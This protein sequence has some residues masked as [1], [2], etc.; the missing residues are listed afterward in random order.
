MP[1]MCFGRGRS[2]RIGTMVASRPAV[3]RSTLR[4]LGLA[5]AWFDVVLSTVTRIFLAGASGAIG[6]PLTIMLVG[7]G[8]EVTGTSRT[9]SGAATITAAG[10]RAVI[11]DV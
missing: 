8:H 7:A 9:D 10:A 5:I 2:R 3:R 11:V 1:A 4:R 6:R